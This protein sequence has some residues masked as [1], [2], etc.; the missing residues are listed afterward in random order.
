MV[1]ES[2]IRRQNYVAAPKIKLSDIV[3]CEVVEK[4]GG[5]FEV[6]IPEV[7]IRKD[8]YLGETEFT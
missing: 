4:D 7:L 2:K 8:D 5:R 6:K 1:V 3:P